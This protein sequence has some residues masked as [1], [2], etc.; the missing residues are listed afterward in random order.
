MTAKFKCE[1]PLSMNVLTHDEGENLGAS[2]H[3]V[4]QALVRLDAEVDTLAWICGLQV[5]A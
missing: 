5:A 2:A 3:K 4:D 1:S